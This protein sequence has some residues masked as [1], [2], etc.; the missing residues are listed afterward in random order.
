MLIEYGYTTANR[1]QLLG[2]MKRNRTQ[3]PSKAVCIISSVDGKLLLHQAGRRD[4]YGFLA[5]S[6]RIIPGIAPEQSIAGDAALGR[7]LGAGMD[8]L[9]RMVTPRFM[10]F[11][12]FL[13]YH[14]NLVAPYSVG[15]NLPAADIT[16]RS[17]ERHRWLD[18]EF[19]VETLNEQSPT[20][21]PIVEDSRFA[22]QTYFDIMHQVEA[23]RTS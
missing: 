17:D 5:H 18:P 10:R 9:S 22:L 1:D 3:V 4:N 11:Y 20:R 19:V 2:I 23:K 13:T 8:G 14:K 6:V 15:L 21:N 12:R 16:L 7:L